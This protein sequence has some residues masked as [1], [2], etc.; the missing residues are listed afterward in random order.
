MTTPA[1]ATTPTWGNFV[2]WGSALAILLVI[3]VMAAGNDTTSG[4]ATGIMWLTVFG[5]VMYFYDPLTMELTTL[6]GIQLAP[7]A[8]TVPN[9]SGLK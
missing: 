5:A 7:K 9:P 3:G 6:T 1:A 8:G 2:K 4:A